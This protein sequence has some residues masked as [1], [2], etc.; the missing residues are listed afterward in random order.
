MEPIPHYEKDKYIGSTHF[1]TGLLISSVEAAVKRVEGVVRLKADSG[2]RF[3]NLFSSS[4]WRKGV[5]IRNVGYGVIV[6]EV[7]VNILH[8][9][10]A[11]DISYRIQEAILGVAQNKNITDKRIKR[12]N[13]RIGNVVTPREQAVEQLGL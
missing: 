2:F 10:S 12:V 1:S 11:A 9:Y 13:V 5:A 6:L 4:A 8:G 3:R 7:C